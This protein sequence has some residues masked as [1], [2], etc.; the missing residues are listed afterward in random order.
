MAFADQGLLNKLLATFRVEAGEHIGVISSG[1]IELEQT[2]SP[3]RRAELVETVFREAHSL[4]GAARAVNLVNVEAVCQSLESTFSGLRPSESIPSPEVFNQ[5]H[6]TV[7]TLSQFLL[8][9][10]AQTATVK[11]PS[12]PAPED[13][14]K[15]PASAT[16]RPPTAPYSSPDTVR[17]SKSKLDSLLRQAEELVSSK[18]T[19]AHWIAETR[20]VDAAL[21]RSLKSFGTMRSHAVAVQRSFER[22]DKQGER[23]EGQENTRKS[24]MN[25]AELLDREEGALRSIESQV[26]SLAK[27]LENE[28]RALG[29]RVDD[30]LSSMRD[31]SMIPSSSMLSIFPKLVRDLCRDFDK[32]AELVIV[33]GEIE[34]D[35]RLL[36]EIKEP[37]I[38]LVRNCV[39]HGIESLRE[40]QERTKPLRAKI[41]I[42]VSTKGSDNIEITV[43]DD[44][45]GIDSQ[46][47]QAAAVKLGVVSQEDAPGMDARDT[48][49]LVFQSGVSTSLT[50]TEVSGRG[51]GLAIVRDR[52]EKLGG[53]VS[54]ETRPGAGTAFRLTLPL[55]IAT[56]RGVLVRVGPDLFVL[57]TMHVQ[58]VLR[59]G[60]EQIRSAENRETLQLNGRAVSCVR[61]RDVLG[62]AGG[63]SGSSSSQKI[64]A[65]LLTAA[66]EEV[67]FLVDEILG[68]Q[69]VVVKGLG[70][71][72]LRVR[73]VAGA[74]ILGTGKVVAVLNVADLLH[75]AI[76]A[77]FVAQIY[78]PDEQPKSILVAE[79]S[80]TGRTLLKN[81][82]ESA[83][84]N[85]K[86]AVDG[87]EAFAMLGSETFD[88]M[89]S[90]VDMPAMTGLDLTEK[91]RAHPTLSHLPVVLVT[92]LDSREDRE[93]GIRVGANAYIVKS[94]FDQSNLLEV[95]RTL[96]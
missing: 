51:L 35:R 41:T 12:L 96:V 85:V 2:L 4:K 62:I 83:G 77:P 55:T 60:P 39:D 87:A 93:A 38:H 18:A 17:I 36:E 21:S 7:D 43:A 95:I 5:L 76:G 57:P 3:E 50:I 15:A 13:K 26:A 92:A 11:E 42:T 68:E 10:A 16:A 37:L 25:L 80:I 81:I 64:P 74:T 86:T 91:I 52:V 28:H 67:A 34:A 63:Y 82:L 94:S 79:D 75:T 24:I 44:G 1:L 19:G 56:F 61:L 14:R 71:H 58:R 73:N 54:V 78:E 45:G 59:T 88:L 30:L 29:R 27:Y 8:D 46:K 47:L 31:A 65:L 9:V 20:D 23:L 32:D 70:K 22:G 66:G 90:D 40:R 49:S 6:R 69:E 53:T 89:V 84:Y 48:L 72:L 33:G